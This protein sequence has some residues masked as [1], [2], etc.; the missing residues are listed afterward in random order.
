MAF[1]KRTRAESFEPVKRAELPDEEEDSNSSLLEKIS[2]KI[3]ALKNT[4]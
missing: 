4:K 3:Q 2:K 1:I